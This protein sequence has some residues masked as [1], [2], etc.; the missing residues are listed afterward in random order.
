MVG[1]VVVRVAP[2]RS[3]GQQCASSPLF[4]GGLPVGELLRANRTMGCR[5]AARKRQPAD[6]KCCGFCDKRSRAIDGGQISPRPMTYEP[7]L[8]VIE[9]RGQIS[10]RSL[11][12]LR[13][14]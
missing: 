3:A 12:V 5:P 10:R 4:V 1:F 11:T 7:L 8:I 9:R 14:E 13:W 6:V 2:L